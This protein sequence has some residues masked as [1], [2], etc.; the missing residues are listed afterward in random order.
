MP[1]LSIPVLGL[2]LLLAASAGY[3][4]ESGENF[5][6][7]LSA[8][9]PAAKALQRLRDAHPAAATRAPVVAAAIEQA[10]AALQSQ[11]PGLQLQMSPET[12]GP[13]VVGVTRG[14]RV[15]TAPSSQR[16]E[17]VARN[18]VERNAALYGLSTAAAADLELDADYAN[19][20][21]NLQ[22][23]RLTQTLHGL[24]VFRGEL[25]VAL[26]P[27]GEIVRTVGQVAPGLDPAE[28]ATT[29]SI[30]A[31]QA[32]VAAAA[33][34]DIALAADQLSRRNS[35]LDTRRVV[36]A[37]DA[38]VR[39]TEVEAVYFPLGEGA[40]DLAWSMVLWMPVDAWYILVS[41]T[42]GTTLFRKNI[43]ES[44][45]FTYRVFNDSSPAPF[46][47]GPVAPS[48]VQ[49]PRILAS[50]VTV[51]SQIASGNPA[52][53]PWLPPG[54]TVTD[55]NNVEAGLDIVA[56]NGVDAPVPITAPNAFL[57]STNPAPGAPAPGEAPSTAN[58]RN[59]AVV[60][61]FYWTNRFHDLTY[62]LGFTEPARNFQ[63]NNYGRGGLGGDRVSAE[64]QDSSGTNNANFS[65]P[66]DG[67]RGR[68][69]MYL[70]TNPSPARDGSFDADIVIHELAHGL[71][72]RL[73]ANASGL[74][75]NMARGMGEGWSDFYAHAFL[76]KPT[77]PIEG[78]YTTG[79]YATYLATGGYVDNYYYGIRRFP[80]AVMSFTGGPN[81][82]PHN[83]LTFADID[84]LQID[85]TDGAYPRGPFGAAQADGVH[86]AGEVWS[87]ALWE[88]RALIIGSL[89]FEDGNQ[90]I[91]QLVTDGMKLSPANP[92]FLDSRDAIVAADCAAFDGSSEP[93][94]L[95]GFAIRGMGLGAQV[96]QAASPARVVE[97]FD[98]PGMLLAG[99]ADNENLSCSMP[100][101]NPTPGDIV[102]LQLPLTNPYC[103]IELTNVTV[104]IIGGN[105]TL[106]GTL[107]GAET[108]TA[109]VE[110]QIPADAVCGQTMQIDLAITHDSG[111]QNVSLDLMVGLPSIQATSFSNPAPIVIPSVGT[112]SV[113]PSS[114]TVS[115]ITDPVVGARVQL[116]GLTHT[117]PNDVDVLLVGPTGQTLV[118]LSDAFGGT[119]A[120]NADN[121]TILLRDDAASAAPS[122]NTLLTGFS[123]YRPTNHGAG[124]AFAVPAPAGPHANPEPAG[125]AKLAN[126]A[127]LN[128]NGTWNLFVVDDT[129]GDLGTIASGWTLSILTAQPSICE[130]CLLSVGGN[131]S[132]LRPG[133][134][135][136]VQIN[137]GE[138]LP[139]NANG[140]FVFPSL[141]ERGNSYAVEVSQQST[142]TSPAQ[143][144]GVDNG[145]GTLTGANIDDIVIECV[146]ILA[147]RGIL[148]G[149]AGG[150][151]VSLQLNGGDDLVITDNG[152]FEFL[153]T[154][155]DGSQYE[156]LV[157]QSPTD[158]N[159]T[160][161]VS[162]GT[163]Q[164]NG[165]DVDNV[166]VDCTI[167]SYE[168]NGVLSGLP[169]GSSLTLQLNGGET[170][171]LDA[172][173]AFAFPTSLQDGSGYNVEISAQP[174]G[175]PVV[176][177]VADGAGTVQGSAASITVSCRGF[178]VF[179]NG[180]EP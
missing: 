23:I 85:L 140:A 143:F 135:M 134:N 128:P 144:C 115:G 40:V 101:R 173:G 54:A 29:P 149:L 165:A 104:E 118:V 56:P 70:W 60:N 3:A 81:N 4:D 32:V 87:S 123:E 106:V 10:R 172:D 31:A 153:Q 34:I 147:V 28:A 25:T 38:F 33:D 91:L 44:E 131:L 110:Y 62:D 162:N 133:A 120:G 150:T 170:L 178:D 35:A 92:T 45:A 90:R 156:V 98:G 129:S 43:T 157:S 16:A 159:Q 26:T 145:N 37:S 151:S 148:N 27:S 5:D 100:D 168:I 99:I 141:I 111:A 102:L 130:A 97:S 82:R 50:D 18:F 72:N 122:A 94:L 19:P 20:A 108:A 180:F 42:D 9:K 136:T 96:L 21:G 39:D 167:D 6:I 105:S 84:S 160:C 88:A 80:K 65:T 137:A 138:S 77:D 52:D 161:T 116:N 36:F 64:A 152:P 124:D 58:A 49:A 179:R 93:A 125:S 86:N 61:L 68:M 1:K 67:G 63:Q 132:G 166:T 127:G 17:Y 11:V 103:S 169:A 176:C 117:W 171:L 14:L 22:W 8:D 71:S 57:Y 15:L 69:Q 89:G 47:P 113:Y 146:D 107:A 78:I 2:F 59:S 73:H 112:G 175:V 95:T 154:L 174:V 7:R 12:G 41:A 164:I 177:A 51:V 46:L 119:A 126:F 53:H 163:G 76:A 114:I 79:G 48:G 30:D 24:P 121:A 75:T 74:G 155:A 109:M 139:L 66:A 158:P 13:E 142:A 55:G 83:P